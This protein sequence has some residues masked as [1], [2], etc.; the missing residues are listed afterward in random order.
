MGFINSSLI[1]IL[2]IVILVVFIMIAWN[3][4]KIRKALEEILK[5]TSFKA[6]RDGII[7]EK[8]CHHCNKISSFYTDEIPTRC[9]LC[10]KDD[11]FEI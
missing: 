2:S 10:M 3:I 7:V 9:P 4:G 5:I 8:Q 6:K 11:A 1:E